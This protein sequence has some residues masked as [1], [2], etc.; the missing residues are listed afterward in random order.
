MRLL[1]NEVLSD[2]GRRTQ[3]R[4]PLEGHQGLLSPQR[5]SLWSVG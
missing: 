1:A 2:V 5:S 4:V 3:A